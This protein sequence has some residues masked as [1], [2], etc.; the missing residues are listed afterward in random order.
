MNSL[1]ERLNR[2]W[3]VWEIGLLTLL[4]YIIAGDPPPGIN[5]A[6]YLVKAKHFWEPQWLSRDVFV[7]SKNAHVAFFAIFGWF[8][9]VFDLTTT[10]WIGRLVGWTSLAAG[11]FYFCKPLLQTRYAALSVAA[12]W[13]VGIQHANL[14]GEWVIGGIESKVLAYAF[15]LFGLGQILRCRW[16]WVWILLGVASAFHVLVGGWS[17]VIALVVRVSVKQSDIS[18]IPGV[19][20]WL[21]LFLGGAI[22]LFGL[23]PSLSLS[24]QASAQE[25]KYAAYL[26]AYGRLRHHLS[27]ASFLLS[28]YVRHGLLLIATICAGRYFYQRLDQHDRQQW[29]LLYSF[30]IGAVVLAAIGLALGILPTVNPMLAAKFLRF[31]WFRMSDAVTPL[32]A[33]VTVTGMF[34]IP[35]RLHVQQNVSKW[36]A[37]ASISV[38]VI[39]IGVL[40]NEF[41]QSLQ[42]NLPASVKPMFVVYDASGKRVTKWTQEKVLKDWMSVCEWA[43]QSTDD[44]ALFLTPRHQQTFKWYARRAEFVNWKDVP[45]DAVSLIE[46]SRRINLAFPQFYSRRHP[47]PNV[48]E[49]SELA[50]QYEIDYLIVDRRVFPKPLE[51]PVVYPPSSGEDSVYVVYKF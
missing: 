42:T 15:V 19:T 25:A 9:Q 36:A 23:L 17:V 37:G 38:L 11:L 12:I 27:P 6:H 5:E 4:F 47:T 21:C 46:W 50:R 51:L 34:V 33:A 31:Y 35:L 30:A 7:N 40:S 1:N 32:A 49:L 39:C 45:Q 28:W 44:D 2:W 16:N 18:R 3:A 8:T 24:A 29:K 13:G 14:A 20:E 48:D 26:Y 41:W 10:A 43:R 22:S